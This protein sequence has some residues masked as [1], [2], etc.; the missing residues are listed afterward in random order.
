MSILL[1]T[2]FVHITLLH[3]LIALFSINT[4][5]SFNFGSSVVEY[6]DSSSPSSP[7]PPHHHQSL[8]WFQIYYQLLAEALLVLV[9]QWYQYIVWQGTQD[10]KKIL[11]D[12][13]KPCFIYP[14]GS[15]AKITAD[16]FSI[17]SF[18]WTNDLSI[19]ASLSIVA[20]FF[21]FLQL[22]FLWLFYI[23]VD[24]LYQIFNLSNC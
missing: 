4:F 24:V 13:A 15:R 5:F 6:E 17:S 1:Q 14:R 22:V 7:P 11:T 12:G 2:T 21:F 20:K 10:A 16:W 8:M 19:A 3:L 23:I 9:N 18:N